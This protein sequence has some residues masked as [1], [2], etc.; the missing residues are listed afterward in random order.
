M[1]F[2]DFKNEIRMKRMYDYFM[3]IRAKIYKES[4]TKIEKAYLKYKVFTL[5][6]LNCFL[7]FRSKRIMN[8]ESL[9]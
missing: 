6:K 8:K 4:V 1:R 7:N 2:D 9:S 3:N 5:N